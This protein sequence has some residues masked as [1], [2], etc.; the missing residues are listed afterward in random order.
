MSKNGQPV[1]GIDVGALGKGFHAVILH[2]TRMKQK[3]FNEVAELVHWCVEMEAQAV[4]VDAPC[5]WAVRG[6]SRLAER[7]LRIGGNIVQCFKTPVREKAGDRD[8]YA[9]VRNGELLYAALK[10]EFFLFNGQRTKKKTVLETFPHAVV[11]ALKGRVV[12]AR[13]KAKNR[14]EMLLEQGLDA[15]GLSNVDFVDAALCA[16]TAKL[17]LLDGTLSFGNLEEGF[18]VVPAPREQWKPNYGIPAD[19]QGKNPHSV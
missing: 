12:P 1:I 13:P 17:F 16:L 2:G 4:A 15:T 10:K 14:R 3:P 5:A 19:A 7:S 18:I 6:G 11:C 8:F 9:W